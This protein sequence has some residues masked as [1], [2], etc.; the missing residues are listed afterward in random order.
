MLSLIKLSSEILHPVETDG[1]NPHLLPGGK[2]DEP[3]Y[4]KLTSAKYLLS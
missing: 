2:F 3:S 4:L 1:K